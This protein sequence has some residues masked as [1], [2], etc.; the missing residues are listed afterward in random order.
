MKTD[1][2][3]IFCIVIW[4]LLFSFLISMYCKF[5]KP[6]IIEEEIIPIEIVVEDEEKD[7]KQLAIDFCKYDYS[8]KIAEEVIFQCEKYNLPVYVV[9]AIIYT[10][11]EFK[12][13]ALSNK[14]CRGLI[15]VS[16][17]CLQDYNNKHTEQYTFD[18]MY[19]IRK[20]LQVGIWHYQRY[21]KYVEN[22]NWVALYAIYNNGLT[23]YNKFGT[24]NIKSAV[25]RFEFYL[26]KMEI[27]FC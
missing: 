21:R 25:E 13:K 22:D 12:S 16:E 17:S 5:K 6:E 9:Y 19:D 14:S 11:S 18:E 26:E 4:F 10:E 27:Y 20:N 8:K 7:T 24:E 3:L 15:Q 23:G 2:L 1:K